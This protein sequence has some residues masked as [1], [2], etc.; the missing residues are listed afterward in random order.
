MAGEK[1]DVIVSNPPYIK[2]EIIK[3]LNKEVQKEPR[4]ALDGGYDGLDFYRKI[5]PEAYQ[6]LK[7]RGFL[8]LEIGYDQKRDVLEMIKDEGK[9]VE[10]Y[11]KKDLYDRDR[12]VCA[13]IL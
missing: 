1:F 10:E 8:C 9:Y 6:Y 3:T 5:I 2:K 7:T 12:V 4:I 11:S 13:R